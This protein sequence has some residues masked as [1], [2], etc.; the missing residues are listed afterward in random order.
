MCDRMCADATAS[1]THHTGAAS[2]AASVAAARRA[3]EPVSRGGR[4]QHNEACLV[5]KASHPHECLAGNAAFT[6][7]TG[8]R[9]E[10]FE[11][12]ALKMLQD[13]STRAAWES[14]IGAAL[15]GSAHEFQVQC[16]TARSKQLLLRVRAAPLQHPGED[17]EQPGL[18][19]LT[20]ARADDG[21]AG[22]APPCVDETRAR[23]V[24]KNKAPFHVESVS[25]GWAS[26]YGVS[27]AAVLGR[28][29]KVVQ[30][31][32]TDMRAA[33]QLMEA[34]AQG[35]KGQATFVTYNVDGKRFWSHHT[36]SPCGPNSFAVEV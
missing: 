5:A 17:G 18:I 26:M 29:L 15:K 16:N 10:H 6:E 11:G 1:C 14:A 23:A 2:S 34:G 28:S 8:F 12:M 25:A 36:T 20:M 24:V 22:G 33:K 21:K 32:G 4:V 9:T 7:L 31:P 30:G 35:A 3:L 13:A 27:E 19:V